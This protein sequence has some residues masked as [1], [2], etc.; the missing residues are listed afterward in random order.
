MQVPD[1]R[2][3]SASSQ[4]W[5][6]FWFS[7]LICHRFIQGSQAAPKHFDGMNSGDGSTQGVRLE[8]ANAG[9]GQNSSH[10]VP[11]VLPIYPSTGATPRC[12]AQ[13]LSPL[14]HPFVLMPRTLSPS[15]SSSEAATQQDMSTTASL[16]FSS[17][18]HELGA[19]WTVFSLLRWL[20]NH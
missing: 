13:S 7:P 15:I 19:L 14:A 17:S 5:L 6:R 3:T 4:G 18:R 20:N 11:C 2:P 12:A 9:C 8:E 16:Q 10:C 1:L